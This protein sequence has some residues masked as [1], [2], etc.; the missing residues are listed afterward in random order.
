MEVNMTENQKL[1]ERRISDW[2]KSGISQKKYCV[3][4]NINYSTFNYWRKKSR[5]KTK[6]F[7]E[8]KVSDSIIENTIVTINLPNGI[9]LSLNQ[10]NNH[11]G[12]K[13]LVHELKDIL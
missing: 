13:E 2:E 5:A 12:V 4:E 6:Q 3:R 1:W 10:L 11:T 9:C 8:I 7:M